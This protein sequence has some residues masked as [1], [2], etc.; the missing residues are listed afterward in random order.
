MDISQIPHTPIYFKEANANSLQ[1][2]FLSF[3]RHEPGASHPYLHG[4][5]TYS[6]QK[7]LYPQCEETKMRSFNDLYDI[8]RTYFPEVTPKEVFE[9]LIA[10]PIKVK[11]QLGFCSTMRRIRFVY[12]GMENRSSAVNYEEE[13]TS[14]YPFSWQI[15][16]KELGMDTHA[17]LQEYIQNVRDEVNSKL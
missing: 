11:V 13:S 4:H 12:L 3:F 1:D 5:K 10:L 2:L 9:T 8:A 15:L 17:K 6:D 14:G 16:G 7:F